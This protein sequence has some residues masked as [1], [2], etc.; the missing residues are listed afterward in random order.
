MLGGSRAASCGAKSM[1]K[2]LVLGAGKIGAL[3]SGLLSESGSW[4]VQLADKD[5]A[6]SQG[7]VAAHS[8]PDLRGL[9]LDATDAAALQSHLAAHP[10]DAVISSL[11][12]Y[13]N[14]TVAQA[15][16]RANVHYFD[17]TEDVEVTRA[18]RATSHGA[19]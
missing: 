10:V 16:R 17:L 18:V 4:E 8:A 2:V 6:A 3:I 7:V 1:H 15:A 14:P 5:G 19:R 9:A 12:Y 13:C 11:P